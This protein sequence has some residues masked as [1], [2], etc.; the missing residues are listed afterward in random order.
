MD[1]SKKENFLHHAYM[2]SYEWSA[3]RERKGNVKFYVNCKRK[4]EQ[5][6]DAYRIEECQTEFYIL[7][8]WKQTCL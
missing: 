3:F 2:K 5:K 8:T 4:R 7:L 1:V 6:T